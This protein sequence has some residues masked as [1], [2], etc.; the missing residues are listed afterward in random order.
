VVR[1]RGL[2]A[3]IQSAVPKRCSKARFAQSAAHKK[4]GR[5]HS[6]WA[7]VVTFYSLL[8]DTR[9]RCTPFF[10]SNFADHGSPI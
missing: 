3:R 1:E 6:V 10:T 5:S 4:N 7:P 9:D 2:K 8:V